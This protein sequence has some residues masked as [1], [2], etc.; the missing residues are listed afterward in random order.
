MKIGIESQRIFR[1]GKH[2]MD[3]VAI[4]LIRQLQRLDNSNQ[5][6]LFAREGPDKACVRE[7]PRFRIEWLKGITYGDWE[8]ISLPRALKRIRPD[9]LHCTANTAPLN[10]PVPLVV[11]VHDVIFLQDVNFRGSTYQNFGNLYRKL[12]V[13]RVLKKAD[14]IITVSENE[15]NVIAEV[16]GIDPEKIVVVPNA[17]DARFNTAIS[18]EQLNNFRKKYRLPHTY[19]LHLGNTAPKKNTEAMLKAYIGYCALAEDPLPLVVA[20]FPAAKV[21]QILS[22]ERKENL[23]ANIFCP[24]YIPVMEMPML[25][26]CASLFVYPSLNES[27]GL[28]MLEAMAS[29]VPVIASAIPALMEVGGDAPVFVDPRDTVAMASAITMMMSD[30]ALAGTCVQKGLAR[31]SR[32]SWE[33]SAAQLLNIYQRVAGQ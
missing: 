4:E 6:V 23:L 30:I 12:I 15:K 13:P 8:Q 19:L 31:A 10:C 1:S 2:G 32:F 28:P 3:V 9:L 21:K 14:M 25:Y 17:V 5:Y 24:G 33:K 22:Q 11:T 7:T 18:N 20:D 27:F 26:R 16:G 29:G